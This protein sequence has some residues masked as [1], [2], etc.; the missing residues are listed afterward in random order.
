MCE[1]GETV[2]CVYS[3]SDTPT[4]QTTP[5]WPLPAVRDLTRDG[6]LTILTMK[7][8]PRCP[9]FHSGEKCARTGHP[10]KL[11]SPTKLARLV[12]GHIPPASHQAGRLAG[13]LLYTISFLCYRPQTLV[14]L[15][16]RVDS[17]SN[18]R[19]KDDQS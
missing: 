12:N 19:L 13:P 16:N 15:H 3:S 5:H 14:N 6:R 9:R 4:L 18:R 8:Y 11:P 17:L 7:V 10:L 2:S 1:G